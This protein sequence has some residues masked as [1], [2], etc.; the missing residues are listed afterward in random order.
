MK[1]TIL[2]CDSTGFYYFSAKGVVGV[3]HFG[4][5]M[6]HPVPSGTWALIDSKT[7]VS[8]PAQYINGNDPPFFVVQATSPRPGRWQSW[9]KYKAPVENF[10]MN[11]FTFEE[12]H[13][14]YVGEPPY[15]S[16][17][18]HSCIASRSRN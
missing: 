1:D 4:K 18:I 5:S 3:D 2:Q 9:M 14:G 6:P 15:Q 8:E 11:P 17:L 13:V 7:K 16:Y 10:Y 12:L